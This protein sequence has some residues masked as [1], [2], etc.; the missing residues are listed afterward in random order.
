[1]K[2]TIA[3]SSK[4]DVTQALNE[5]SSQIDNE[6]LVFL[7]Y[8]SDIDRFEAFTIGLTQKYPN[9]KTMGSSSYVVFTSK[10]SAKKGIG[11]LALYDDSQ[12][13]IGVLPDVSS[14]FNVQYIQD[15]VDCASLIP[16]N[17]NTI[18]L[19]LTSAFVYAEENTLDILH[20]GL[21]EDIEIFGGTAGNTGN[22]EKTL[23]AENGKVYATACVFALMNLPVENHINL[24]HIYK[25]T[26]SIFTVTE[27]NPYKRI[28][29]E[30]DKL[31]AIETLCYACG[32]SPDKLPKFLEEHPLGHLIKDNQFIIEPDSFNPDGSISFFAQ[33]YKHSQVAIFDESRIEDVF[34]KT[35][36]AVK[37]VVPYPNFTIAVNCFARS[38]S[39]EAKNKWQSFM[40]SLNSYA[41][42]FIGMS[43]YGEQLRTNHFN[44]TLVTATFGNKIEKKEELE[45]EEKID[46]LTNIDNEKGFIRDCLA[47]IENNQDTNY[48]IGVFNINN[49]RVI[50]DTYGFEKGDEVLREIAENLKVKVDNIGVCAHLHSD[51]FAFS[52]PYTIENME[53]I[54]H[55]KY[56]ECNVLDIPYL[57]S[58]RAGMYNISDICQGLPSFSDVRVALD[59]SQIALSKIVNTSVNSFCFYND[60]M[61]TKMLEEIEVTSKMREA[62]DNKEFV[63]YYQ[64]QFNHSTGCLVGAEALC[65]WIKPNGSIIS[66]GIFIPIF[67]KN[68]FILQLDKYIWDRAF[69]TVSN[70][71][72][73]GL[74]IVPISVNISRYSL[75]NAGLPQIFSRLCLKYDVK[76]QYI[77]LEFTESSYMDNQE[78]IIT[79]AK[80]LRSLGFEIAM[81]DFGS[82]YSSLNTLKDLPIDILKFDM[83]FVKGQ[84]NSSRGGIIMVAL[85]R[86][87]QNL[88][89]TTIVEGVEDIDTANYLRSI[90]SDIIQGYLYSR[91]VPQKDFEQILVSGKR[92]KIERIRFE[93]EISTENFFN[94]TSVESRLF[95]DYIGP[96]AVFSWEDKKISIT[97]VNDLYLK[98]ICC[99]D[100]ELKEV[101]TN[102]FKTFTAESKKIFIKTV[103]ETIKTKK[104]A[105]CVTERKV[106]GKKEPVWIKSQLWC[107]ASAGKRHV[108]YALIDNV[109]E[110]KNAEKKANEITKLMESIVES[111]QSGICLFRARYAKVSFTLKPIYINDRFCEMSNYSKEQLFSFSTQDFINIIAKEDRAKYLLEVPSKLLRD[112]KVEYVYHALGNDKK[113]YLVKLST[114]IL[115]QKDKSYLVVMHFMPLDD[116]V[117][118]SE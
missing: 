81:D 14:V 112:K 70:W 56:L 33:V 80:N 115:P 18:C 39:F 2:Y 105:V 98:E 113:K 41:G 9:I 15:V 79:T 65:R 40:H 53:E 77:H 3:F 25:P 31:P 72:K 88:G 89:L 96:A 117:Q 78:L 86:M 114:T 100:I 55:V 82:G 73:Q 93:K 106:K 8:F 13:E 111:S 118:T 45:Y 32:I 101:Q 71:L 69:E 30:I 85:M 83:G 21:G 47:L 38:R 99:E 16:T 28:I 74:D 29:Y 50:N 95:N 6:K 7:L 22:G 48:L 42:D 49:F 19:E 54:S 103:E 23:V 24:E 61:H 110:L 43:G 64:P 11:V 108:I 51:T 75:R 35:N 37:K 60:Q 87:A 109:S 5:I 1:M 34:S 76:P 26:N 4:A 17:R 20:K 63:L 84:E 59:Y 10:G 12:I 68:G 36:V 58:A 107:V 92:Q 62:L 104:S 97:R 67:E 27:A 52:I 57:L 44:H 116:G 66:P 94:P 102:F 90:G 46:R 91:P